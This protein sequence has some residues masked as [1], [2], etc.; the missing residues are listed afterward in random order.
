MCLHVFW[1]HV[2]PLRGE[3][4][5]AFLLNP[6]LD[7]SPG[8]PGRRMLHFLGRLMGVCL[9]RGDS[10]KSHVSETTIDGPATNR[11]YTLANFPNS[12]MY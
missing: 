3:H 4:R 9:R 12:D 2:R 5:D 11:T 8:S 10:T 1:A 7:V 6:R